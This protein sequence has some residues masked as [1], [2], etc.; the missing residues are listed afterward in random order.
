MGGKSKSGSAQKWAKP[1]A[2]AGANAAQSV[3][4]QNQGATQQL[5]N[6]VRGL[7]PGLIAKYNADNPNVGAAQGYNADVLSGKYRTGNPYLS[8]LMSNTNR[9]IADDVNS[10]FSMA[11]RYGSGAHTGVL[12]DR[13]AEAD[14]AL[15]YGDY[16]NQMTR[17]DQQ[18]ALAPTLAQADYIGLD[19]ILKSAGVG[20]ELPYVGL[21]PYTSALANLFSGSKQKEGVGGMIAS[22]I[23]SAASGIAMSDR[24]VKRDIE[25]VGELDD[26]LGVYEWQYVWGGPR[27]R[28]VMADEVETLR[29]WALGPRIAGFA[30]VNYG[31]L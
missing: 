28:G 30:T 9:R 27:H 6:D 14:N 11:G 10:Q 15:M 18:A 13:M 26:G 8:E 4:N 17:M 3:F 31:A 22:G 16:N 1:Y 19:E 29:P 2:I 7:V 24:R 23:G 20:A 12:T 21:T 5:A 25:R